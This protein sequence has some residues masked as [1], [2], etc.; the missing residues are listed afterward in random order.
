MQAPLARTVI[1]GLISSTLITLII[2]PVVYLLFD[3]YLLRRKDREKPVAKVMEAS[4]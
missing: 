2:I 1:G 4:R 3:T